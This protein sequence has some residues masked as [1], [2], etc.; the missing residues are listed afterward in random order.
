LLIIG[1]SAILLTSSVNRVASMG[2]ETSLSSAGDLADD[3]RRVA[4]SL[5]MN[6][7]EKRP[8]ADDSI[9]MRKWLVESNLDIAF[10]FGRERNMIILSDSLH[11]AREIPAKQIHVKPGASVIAI[12]SLHFLIYSIDDS[13]LTRGCGMLL[14]A[15]YG[16]K[17]NIVARALSVAASL[18]I[19]KTF[20]ARLLIIAIIAAIALSAFMAVII[21]GFLSRKLSHPLGE[22]ARSAEIIGGGNLDHRATI[23]GRDEF[24]KL[25]ES[26]NAMAFQIKEHQQKLLDA[27]RLA[28]W[29]EVAR[30]VAHEIKNPLVP[31]SVQLYRL[32][33]ALAKG[34][35]LQ[36][37]IEIVE[38]IKSQL[39]VL[40]DLA[41]QFSTF[42]KEPQLRLSKCK[43]V[44]IIEGLVPSF[45][46]GDRISVKI[47]ADP[48]L[49]YLNIDSNMMIRVFGNLL[50]N[51]SEAL[52]NG[53][54]IDVSVWRNGQTVE[55][56]FRDNGP[57][58]PVNKLQNIDKPYLTTKPGGTGL[59]LVII[60]NIIEEHEGTIEFFN[61]NGAVIK[62]FLPIT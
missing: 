60:K 18:G 51:S 24:A 36:T 12:D 32:E 53:G 3:T 26:F 17:S 16:A 20:T 7:L 58:F 14:P 28:A 41:D 9:G 8:P 61:D 15:D 10:E 2:L 40:G 27:E 46:F 48:S 43:L 38:S 23:S 56:I 13:L 22:L 31:L 5:L 29:R 35:D 30:R 11:L 57:G 44:S 4:G 49:P 52:S 21:S 42:A 1:V 47:D 39:G 59:G 45:C 55:I 33:T 34:V 37:N 6:S 54:R 50:R 62:I 25:A 19:I